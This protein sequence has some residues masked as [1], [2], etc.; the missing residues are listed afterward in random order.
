MTILVLGGDWQQLPAIRK[1][2]EMGLRVML[3]IIWRVRREGGRSVLSGQHQRLGS[4]SCS[5]RKRGCGW[6]AGFCFGS[7][8]TDGSLCGG[9]VRAARRAT[10]GSGN[11]RK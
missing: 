6:R 1:A 2:C 4:D 8:K 9:G 7:G 10:G 11:S 3:P 5:C